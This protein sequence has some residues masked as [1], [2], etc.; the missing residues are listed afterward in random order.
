MFLPRRAIRGGFGRSHD[1]D[2]GFLVG[3]YGGTVDETT[4]SDSVIYAPK[5]EP[6]DYSRYTND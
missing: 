2:G 6:Q 3:L 4:I 1:N 5:N